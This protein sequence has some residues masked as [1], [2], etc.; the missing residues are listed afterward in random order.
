MV[1]ARSPAYPSIGLREAVER[2]AAVY[3]QDYQNPIPKTV[4]AQHMGY[5]GLNGKSL[6]VLSSL[7]KYGLLEGRGDESRVSDLAVRIIAHPSASP[8]RA[9][10]LQQAAAAPALFAELD[11]RFQGGRASDQAIRSFLLTQKFIP[12]AADI[13]IRSYRETKQFIEA[14]TVGIGEIEADDGESAPVPVLPLGSS[15][16]GTP[17]PR[18]GAGG[19]AE[20]YGERSRTQESRLYSGVMS[21]NDLSLDEPYRIQIRANGIDVVATLSDT[22]AIDRLVKALGAVRYLMVLGNN[23]SPTHVESSS[24]GKIEPASE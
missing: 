17:P 3:Q 2:V 15:R 19:A 20:R 1:K 22:E 10:A 5:V 23:T 12:P 7:S 9:Q 6:G 16:D 4:V 24:R 18:D 21:L 13:A 14:E 11:G 8:E